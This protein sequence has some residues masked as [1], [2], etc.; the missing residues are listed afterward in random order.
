[1]QLGFATPRGWLEHGKRIQVFDAPT[2]FG[3]VSY[4]IDS[5]LEHNQVRVDLEVP[6]R[7]PIENLQLRLRVPAGKQLASV[8]INRH[9]H[10]KLNPQTETIDLTGLTGKLKIIA[11]YH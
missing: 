6:S 11:T 7:T 4:T 9:P 3:P 2:L 8:T 1:L 10:S 5:D